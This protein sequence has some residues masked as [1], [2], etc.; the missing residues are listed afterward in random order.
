MCVF[1][2]CA[3]TFSGCINSSEPC[4]SVLNILHTYRDVHKIQILI[5]TNN[6][7][8]KLLQA[9]LW[10]TLAQGSWRGGNKTPLYD[11]VEQ[12]TSISTPV[13]NAL[14]THSTTKTWR[15][16]QPIST[17]PVPCSADPC[18]SQGCGKVLDSWPKALGLPLA[19]QGK[20]LSES[21]SATCHSSKDVGV[22]SFIQAIFFEAK[23]P[24]QLY[25]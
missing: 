10:L 23:L 3:A 20:K 7:R 1:T 21:G 6:Q 11:T 15:I 16:F 14:C 12:Q 5:L 8:E 9:A 24:I 25:P 2:R 17:N 18:G 19:H 4:I 22:T 13:L